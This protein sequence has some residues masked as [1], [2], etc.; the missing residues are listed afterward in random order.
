MYSI[1]PYQDYSFRC[2]FSNNSVL[3]CVVSV[4]SFSPSFIPFL[5]LFR[6]HCVAALFKPIFL[7]CQD[8]VLFLAYPFNRSVVP[9]LHKFFLPYQVLHPFSTRVLFE[10]VLPCLLFL[11]EC[12]LLCSS[13]L[14]SFF[15]FDQPL[16][17]RGFIRLSKE[18][19][20]FT[21]SLSLPLS[22]RCHSRSRDE[23]L[24]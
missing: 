8:R 6:R 2:W 3:A 15:P 22:L 16:K 17:V 7:F 20:S 5:L 19:L 18:Q 24:S 13:P 1:R 21:P 4:L 14:N 10:F 23:I 12:F 11:T 9:L